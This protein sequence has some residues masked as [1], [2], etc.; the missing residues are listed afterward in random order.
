MKK[1]SIISH[2]NVERGVDEALA[3]DQSGA[4]S[5]SVSETPLVDAIELDRQRIAGDWSQT[6]PSAVA[7]K[8][9]RGSRLALALIKRVRDY[10]PH[11][12]HCDHI[13]QHC[14]EAMDILESALSQND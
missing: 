6:V 4:L 5:C 7:R 14:T 12:S 9:E 8:L 13:H 1:I 2:D 3:Y 11:P 10:D